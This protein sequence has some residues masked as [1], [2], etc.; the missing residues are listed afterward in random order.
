MVALAVLAP[1]RQ[2]SAYRPFDSTDAAVADF[3]ET[4]IEFG[5]AQLRRDDSGTTLIAPAVVYNYGFAKNWELVIEGQGEH[6]LS[7]DDTR[8][9]FVDDAISLKHVLREGVLQGKTGTSVATEFG[10]LLPEIN[11]V[12]NAGA[13]W[14]L[15]MSDRWSWGTIHLNI[16]TAWTREQHPDVFIGTIV[17]GPFDWKVR[18]VAEIRYEREFESK[19]IYSALAGVIWQA[20]DNL[21]FDLAVREAW[22]NGRP[23]TQLRAGV[24]F[25]FAAK[26]K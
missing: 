11:G 22:V 19:E 14:A 26:E 5:P 10:V 16:G 17:E 2:A 8:S 18:P 21:A 1:P 20:R 23:E 15:L 9:S 3:R 4:E 24:T 13:S 25:A 12:P 6:P 7:G